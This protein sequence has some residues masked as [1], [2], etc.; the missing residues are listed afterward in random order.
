[1]KVHPLACIDVADEVRSEAEGTTLTYL[2]GLLIHRVAYQRH[3][4][5][6][7][8]AGDVVTALEAAKSVRFLKHLYAQALELL[9]QMAPRREGIAQ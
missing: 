4:E 9:R 7:L 2:N 5:E 8:A 3:Y 1:M 6:S